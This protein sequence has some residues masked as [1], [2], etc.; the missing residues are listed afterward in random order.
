MNVAEVER[1][2]TNVASLREFLEVRAMRWVNATELED[3]AGR[4]AWRTRV[5]ELRI[6]LEKA[7]Q[8]TIENRIT[9]R[10]RKAVLSEYRY[11]PYQPL[12]R[13]AETVAPSLPLFDN[14]P[15]SRR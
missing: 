12:G 8:G 5:S 15:W 3:V 13:S 14:G 2:K 10:H 6:I 7:D 11:L 4:Q 9:Y 1:R